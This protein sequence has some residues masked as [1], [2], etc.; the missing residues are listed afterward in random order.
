M[1]IQTDELKKTAS[2]LLAAML[3]NPHIYPQISDAG[4]HGNMEQKLII[5]AVEMAESLIQH[6][7]QTHAQNER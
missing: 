3:S 4:G 1:N 2:Q 7:E 6:I 5:I